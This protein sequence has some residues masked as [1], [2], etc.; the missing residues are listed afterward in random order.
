MQRFGLTVAWR[1]T[2]INNGQGAR[3]RAFCTAKS[4]KLVDLPA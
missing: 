4:S 2:E 3:I 1:M